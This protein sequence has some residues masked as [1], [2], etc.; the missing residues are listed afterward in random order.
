VLDDYFP[1]ISSQWDSLAHIAANPDVFYNGASV[2]DV[3]LRGANTID[4]W[5]RRG[6]VT[7]GVLLDVARIRAAEGVAPHTAPSP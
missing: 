3:L 1:Q 4:H 6:I 5:A 7:R 2:D